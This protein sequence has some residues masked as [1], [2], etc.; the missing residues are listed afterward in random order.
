MNIERLNTLLRTNQISQVMYDTYMLY[1]VNELGVRVFNQSY[2]HVM[3]EEYEG[4]DF[5]PAHA[6]TWYDARRSVYRDI[7]KIL[8]TV[9]H[10]LEQGT[11]HDRPSNQ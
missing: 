11:N 7:K 4:A 5:P 10:L 1:R 9:E 6:F 2:E 3:M 8:L